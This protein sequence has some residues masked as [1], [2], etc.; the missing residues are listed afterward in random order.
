MRSAE[1]SSVHLI[2]EDLHKHYGAVRALNGADLAVNRGEFITILGPSGSGKTWSLLFSHCC[3]AT[4]IV[5]VIVSA[6]LQNFNPNVERA[7]QILGA[8]PLQTFSKIV[9]PIIRPG[10]ITGAL[11]AFI[12]SFDEVVIAAFIGGYRMTTLPKKM[13]ENVRDEMDPSVAAISTILVFISVL[14]LLVIGRLNRR[15]DRLYSSAQD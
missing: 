15:R 13:F 6:T 1:H 9:L 10:V 14:L 8:T 11:F 5:I 7:A 12:L 4:P 2:I 3:M